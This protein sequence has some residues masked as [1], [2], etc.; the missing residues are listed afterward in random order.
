MLSEASGT[1]NKVSPAPTPQQ[2]VLL[3]CRVK[4]V[5]ATISFYI[6]SMLE[7]QK[8]SSQPK[9]AVFRSRYPELGQMIEHQASGGAWSLP[10]TTCRS[11]VNSNT[12]PSPVRVENV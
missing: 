2:V 11:T 12:K 4:N 5:F 10:K 8:S 7:K 1:P 3:L 9:R 6:F